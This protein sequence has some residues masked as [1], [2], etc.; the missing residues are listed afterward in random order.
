[1]CQRQHVLK[2]ERQVDKA[3]AVDK[4]TWT[5]QWM[6]Y[7]TPRNS[8]EIQAVKIIVHYGLHTSTAT[9]VI[10][11]LS[12]PAALGTKLRLFCHSSSKMTYNL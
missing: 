11:L 5:E 10:L 6:I 2:T 8:Y 3:I 1:M 12:I 9:G 7:E 4:T